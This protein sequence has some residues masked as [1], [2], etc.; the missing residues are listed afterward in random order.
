VV[1]DFIATKIPLSEDSWAAV[2]SIATTLQT[3]NIITM[4]K[5]GGSPQQS[6][7]KN[8]VRIDK[9]HAAII[10][11][12]RD[13]FDTVIQDRKENAQVYKK[14]KGKNVVWDDLKVT[15]SVKMY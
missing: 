9:I 10:A 7:F 3:T 13:A 1:V 15:D 12:D 6:F 14:I 11:G 5:R 8:T 4:K 2:C